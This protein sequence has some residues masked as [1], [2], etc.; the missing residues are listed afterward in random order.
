MKFIWS[1]ILK[2]NLKV[3]LNRLG[4]HQFYD[5]RSRS[6]SYIRRLGGQQYP[7]FHLYMDEAGS[8]YIFKLHLDEKR[9]SYGVGPRH[10]GQYDSPLVKTELERIHQYFQDL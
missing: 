6:L 10:S 8:N 3:L 1:G 9:P 7:R 2:T 5:R 4:Y